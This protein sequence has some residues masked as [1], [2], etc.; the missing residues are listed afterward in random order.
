MCGK[1]GQ[2][3][4]LSCSSEWKEYESQAGGQ[5]FLYFHLEKKCTSILELTE[6]DCV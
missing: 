4:T 1:K 3:M 6:W 5:Y 2:A